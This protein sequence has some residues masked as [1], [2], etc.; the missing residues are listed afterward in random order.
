MFFINKIFY[1]RNFR[2]VNFKLLTSI[3]LGYY[4]ITPALSLMGSYGSNSFIMP[5]LP[6]LK[7]DSIQAVKSLDSK[8]YI[9][10]NSTAVSV[11]AGTLPYYRPD[12]DFIDP[13]AKWISIFQGQNQDILFFLVI[14][15]GTG[16]I[17]FLNICNVYF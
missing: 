3:L 4:L 7:D 2:E 14:Q 9:P 12:I 17:R 15:N 16:I 8:K 13:W 6:H 1:I 5:E 11:W 10:L